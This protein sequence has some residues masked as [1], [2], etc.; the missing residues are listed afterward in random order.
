FSDARNRIARDVIGLG[1]AKTSFA[2]GLIYPFEATICCID[3]HVGRLLAPLMGCD[4]VAVP[5]R[6]A[7]A[8]ALLE[9]VASAAGLPLVLAHWIRWDHQRHGVGDC[10]RLAHCPLAPAPGSESVRL[11][12]PLF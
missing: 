3:T 1:P 2:L 12:G 11:I 5:R 7:E 4:P 6:Y 8:E 10:S 9:E